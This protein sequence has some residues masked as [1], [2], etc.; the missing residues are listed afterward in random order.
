MNK[1]LISAIM[2]ILSSCYII[3]SYAEIYSYQDEN[4]KFHFTNAKPAKE[5]K[6]KHVDIEN[7]ATQSKTTTKK[8]TQDLQAHLNKK[9]KPSNEI[10]KA[11][12]ATVKIEDINGY[13]SGSGFFINDQGYIITNKHVVRFTE[14]KHSNSRQ[15]EIDL[16]E[17]KIEEVN[18]YLK[19]KKLEMKNYKQKLTDY[20]KSIAQANSLDAKDMQ[21]TYRYYLKRYK[22]DQKKLTKISNQNQKNKKE[23][24]AKKR[25]MRQAKTNN[26]FKITLKD[27]TELRAKLIKLSP[28]I[29]LALLQLIG[30]YKTPLLNRSVKFTQGMDVYAIGSPLG[31][32][33]YV[34]KGVIMGLERGYIVTD[35]QILPGNSGGPLI[36]PDGDVVGINT[37]VYRAGGNIG[38]EVFGYAIPIAAVK[39][40]FS[41]DIP[42]KE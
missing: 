11:T 1:R 2:F 13:S 40:E 3:N 14:S 38:S 22:S 24:T 4:G 5:K 26:I 17:Q 10:E 41:T 19:Q 16:A 35:T 42:Q 33:D 30:N 28:N 27:N 32:K 25:K 29:D 21:T 6:A 20:K 9:I 36:N 34:T 18:A 7:N 31:F 8:I 15:N 23:I 39:K 37:A 12:L